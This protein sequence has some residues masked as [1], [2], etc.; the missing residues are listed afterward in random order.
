MALPSPSVTNPPANCV[1]SK[2]RLA[3]I[4]ALMCALYCTIPPLV[5]MLV[6]NTSGRFPANSPVP[7]RTF[8]VLLPKTS[9]LNPTRGENIQLASG[10]LPVSRCRPLKSKSLIA[11]L[12]TKSLLSKTKLSMRNP[13]VNLKLSVN[14]HSSCA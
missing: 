10:H 2:P 4:P 12:A 3:A 14:D 9:Q 13:Y 6:K 5:G 11:L 8:S 7:P 1:M